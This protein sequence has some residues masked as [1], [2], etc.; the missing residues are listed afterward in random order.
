MTEIIKYIANDGTEFDDKYDCKKYEW[1]QA[2]KNPEFKLLNDD[3]E[4]LDPCDS[5]S[6]SNAAFIFIPNPSAVK[7]LWFAW[8]SDIVGEYCPDF[9]DNAWRRYDEF[10]CECGL[11]AYDWD[12]EEWYHVGKRLTKMTEIANKCM[13]KINA[14]ITKEETKNGKD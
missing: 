10:E 2:L 3:Y 4:I 7:S 1:K 13:E 14:P 12:S 11:W 6:Y 9:I 5:K 8:N